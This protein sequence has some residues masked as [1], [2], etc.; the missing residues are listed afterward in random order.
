MNNKNVLRDNQ[1][2]E[3]ID[4]FHIML[5]GKKVRVFPGSGFEV[6][7]LA[8]GSDVRWVGDSIGFGEAE[9]IDLVDQMGNW[10]SIPART[11]MAH[12]VWS[13]INA[14]GQKRITDGLN[15]RR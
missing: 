10:A 4:A 3:L 1:V 2:C 13:H 7:P 5:D 14:Y 15:T 12:E 6:D 9:F 8:L 11:V